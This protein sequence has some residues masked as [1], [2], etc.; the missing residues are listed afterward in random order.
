MHIEGEIAFS[1]GET[2]Q[3]DVLVEIFTT[4]GAK[5]GE[6]RTEAD[7]LFTF[8]ATSAQQHILKA[9]LGAGH[10]AGDDS[11]QDFLNAAGIEAVRVQ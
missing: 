6:T 1:N 9:N 2:A 11:V 3:S 8:T 5:I 7:G 10:L 4:N